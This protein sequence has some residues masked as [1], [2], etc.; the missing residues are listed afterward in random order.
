MP[1]AKIS[2]GTTSVSV[3]KPHNVQEVYWWLIAYLCQKGWEP[4]SA[5]E[6]GTYGEASYFRFE[7]EE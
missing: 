2:T 6:N 1:Q 5:R 3:E 7:Y 4:F